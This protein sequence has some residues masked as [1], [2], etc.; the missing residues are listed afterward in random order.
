[1]LTSAKMP[2]VVTALKTWRHY[3]LGRFFDLCT[4]SLSVSSLS[5]LCW[6]YA[7]SDG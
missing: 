1:M 5:N 7:K 3:L 4:M 2:T 6:L